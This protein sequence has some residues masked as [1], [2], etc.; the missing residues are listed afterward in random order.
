VNNRVQGWSYDADGR[1]L[2]ANAYYTY[3]AA[4]RVI[5]FGN[6][7]PYKTEQQ[8]SGDGLRAKTV[9]RRF[10]DETDQGG[11]APVPAGISFGYDAAGNRT[12]MTDET[13]AVTYQYDQL[14]RLQSEMRQFA[15]ISGNFMLSYE[16][17]LAGAL[18]AIVDPTGSRVD[19]GYDASA[20]LSSV[21]GSGANSVPTYATGFGYRL[22]G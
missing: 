18:K 15:G 8:F 7:A 5:S 13:G 2:I 10:N 1:A 11:P 20:R 19:Y 14:S 3:D 9:A 22:L 17:N 6:E 16:Y 21:T 4:G 12:S